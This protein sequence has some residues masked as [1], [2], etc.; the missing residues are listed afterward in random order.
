MQVFFKVTVANTS[1]LQYNTMSVWGV[2]LVGA[3]ASVDTFI[4]TSNV[5]A[6]LM[7]SPNEMNKPDYVV[8]SHY[9]A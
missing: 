4:D 1:L 3:L 5:K 7:L 9:L 8:V 6:L 2:Q